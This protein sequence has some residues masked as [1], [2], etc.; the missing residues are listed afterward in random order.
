VPKTIKLRRHLKASDTKRWPK[1][2]VWM[3]GNKTRLDRIYFA[4]LQQ[5]PSYNKNLHLRF[6]TGFIDASPQQNLIR[7]YKKKRHLT[8]MSHCTSLIIWAT[9]LQYTRLRCNYSYLATS[10]RSVDKPFK[11]DPWWIFGFTDGEG[12]F[13]VSIIEN[14][15]YYQG[16]E[17]Q[18]RFQ[19]TL[20]QRDKPLLARIK[21]SLRVGH[22]YKSGLNSVQLQ[23]RSI[24]ELKVII[25]YF[26]KYPL[27][28]QKYSDFNFL[29]MVVEKL[30]ARN[31]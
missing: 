6:V 22:I 31:I 14:K 25:E 29:K 9:N 26:D 4:T 15:K 28:T 18:P 7:Q 1:R 3:G 17:I 20:H 13:R 2:H 5:Q 16:W 11:L 27:I 23:V 30:N 8:Q 24:K 10:R 12:C 19:L 21:N